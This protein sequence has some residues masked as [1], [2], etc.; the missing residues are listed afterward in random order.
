MK[1][2]PHFFEGPYRNAMRLAMEEATH[3]N[4]VHVAPET[5]V[6]P[7]STRGAT[8]TRASWPR[9]STI[10]RKRSGRNCCERTRSVTRRRTNWRDVQR[11]R[12]LIQ[13][14]ELSA[15]RQTLE[16]ASIA[17]GNQDTLNALRNKE[18]RP[19]ARE[20]RFLV[21]FWNSNQTDLSRGIRVSS[22]VFLRCFKT[23]RNDDRASEASVDP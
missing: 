2:I 9:V 11:T 4:V 7:A 22:S 16:G 17:P 8:S 23:F 3:F 1:S 13:M 12:N 21:M 5:L 14:E 10:L 15:G 6:V 19:P 18:R 20:F